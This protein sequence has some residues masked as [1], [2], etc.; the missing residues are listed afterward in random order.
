MVALIAI[1][2]ACVKG[3]AQKKGIDFDETFAPTCHMTTIHSL[4][5]LVAHYGCNVHQL[6]IKRTFFNGDLH[7]EVYVLQ[8][9]E[10]IQEGKEKQ[11]CR[12]KKALYG[13]KQAPRALSMRKYMHT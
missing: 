10:F 1:S 12:L 8:T 4:C 13:L 2:K 9:H 7:E 3:Y 5:A 6:D 11:V